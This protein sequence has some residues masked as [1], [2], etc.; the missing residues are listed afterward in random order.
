MI[1]EKILTEIFGFLYLD[2]K[3]S[4]SESGRNYSLIR[5]LDRRYLN[6][7]Y[8]CKKYKKIDD[9]TCDEKLGECQTHAGSVVSCYSSKDG[10]V[11]KYENADKGIE[12]LL[13]NDSND[14]QIQDHMV[15]LLE[16][17]FEKSEK[18]DPILSLEENIFNTYSK[19]CSMFTLSAMFSAFTQ[20]PVPA[21][22]CAY[23]A[24]LTLI[25]RHRI[26][27]KCANYIDK[28]TSFM[29]DSAED[30]LRTKIIS[31]TKME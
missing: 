16:N 9:V 5:K 18:E 17:T 25:E 19:L 26:E 13:Q 22:Y 14:P 31:V 21:L 6:V 15:S 29:G 28:K 27:K 2:F 8:P 24:I 12:V 3:N 23:G 7:L 11:F 20:H 4:E 30:I 1:K 10:K